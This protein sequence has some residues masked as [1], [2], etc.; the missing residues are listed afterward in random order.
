MSADSPAVRYP[1]RKRQEI[2]YS[3]PADDE[4]LNLESALEKKTTPKKG[5]ATSGGEPHDADLSDDDFELGQRKR[6]KV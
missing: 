5:K 6:K 4:D 3:E 1:K 2:S